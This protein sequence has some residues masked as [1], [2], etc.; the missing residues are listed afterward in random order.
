[1]KTIYDMVMEVS[2][3]VLAIVF[4]GVL[5]S[6]ELWNAGGAIWLIPNGFVYVA[7][8]AFYIK[9]AAKG[10]KKGGKKES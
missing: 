10:I 2:V 5:I 1:M 8:V 4:L 7:L 3:G 9:S 6:L